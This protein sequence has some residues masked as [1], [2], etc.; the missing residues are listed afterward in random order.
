MESGAAYILSSKGLL[1]GVTT[2]LLISDGDEC[3]GVG[4]R[5]E[6]VALDNTP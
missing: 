4:G 5:A 1:G 3:G 2:W 6:D